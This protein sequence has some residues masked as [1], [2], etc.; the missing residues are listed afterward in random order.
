M[1]RHTDTKTPIDHYQHHDFALIIEN[2]DAEGYVSEKFGDA[3]MAGSIPLYYGNPSNLVPL[4]EGCYIDIRN[5]KNG[6]ELQDHLDTLSEEDVARMKQKVY[7]VRTNYLQQRGR[8]R[9]ADAV[10]T[11]LEMMSV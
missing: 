4:P 9:L 6:S 1:D 10:T 5:F 11:A 3:L 8:T 2:C 7:D